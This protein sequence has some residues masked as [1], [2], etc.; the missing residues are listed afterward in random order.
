MQTR[1][2]KRPVR[3][4]G[5][6]WTCLIRSCGA[7]HS[8]DAARVR[9]GGTEAVCPLDRT[10]AMIRPGGWSRSSN[11]SVITDVCKHWRRNASYE[12]HYFIMPRNACKRQGADLPIQHTDQSF[13]APSKEYMRVRPCI[14]E[15]NLDLGSAWGDLGNLMTLLN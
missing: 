10:P 9:R 13:D 7:D 1:T 8:N 11:L 2:G 14:S 3:G 12:Q 15:G 5:R 4:G 6:G